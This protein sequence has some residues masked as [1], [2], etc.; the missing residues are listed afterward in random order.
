MGESVILEWFIEKN[1]LV[2]EGELTRDNLLPLWNDKV[3]LLTHNKPLQA[4]DLARLSYMDSAGFILLCQFLH[5]MSKVNQ[6]VKL[7]NSPTLFMD[8]AEL[9]E[10]SEWLESFIVN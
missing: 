4:I 7:F 6:E 2:I 8:F 1:T 3:R 10:L 9:Y 5:E